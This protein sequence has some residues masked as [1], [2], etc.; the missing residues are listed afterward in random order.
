MCGRS[1]EPFLYFAKILVYNWS[2]DSQVEVWSSG[3]CGFELIDTASLRIRK[4]NVP[5]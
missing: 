5:K 3:K 1:Q 2:E 4:D